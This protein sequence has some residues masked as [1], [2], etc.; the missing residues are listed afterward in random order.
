MA[1]CTSC[2]RRLSSRNAT[3]SGAL[4]AREGWGQAQQEVCVF[5]HEGV[6][7]GD[8]LIV[9]AMTGAM[10][11][12][13]VQ[14]VSAAACD[15]GWY[16]EADIISMIGTTQG[17]LKERFLSEADRVFVSPRRQAHATVSGMSADEQEDGRVMPTQL[18]DPPGTL[19]KGHTTSALMCTN[20]VALMGRAPGI[21]AEYRECKCDGQRGRQRRQ[22]NVGSGL[23]A[24]GEVF[25]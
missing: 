1:R 4:R 18:P 10:G 2:A 14:A 19:P 20:R 13:D 5:K 7:P 11:F 9:G 6:D 8:A 16:A 3:A 21:A 15:A 22:E 17:R 12:S 23:D 24:F 25:S